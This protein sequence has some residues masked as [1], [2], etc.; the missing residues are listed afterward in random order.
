MTDPRAPK[1]K[2]VSVFLVKPGIAGF[3][4]GKAEKKMGQHGSATNELIFQDCRIGGDALMGRSTT[5]FGW[6]S[7]SWPADASASARSDLVSA[8]R[9]W[10]RPPDIPWSGSS[11]SEN[12]PVSGYS[13]EDRRSLYRT[14]SGAAVAHERRLSE[15]TGQSLCQG[16]LDGQAYL[17]PKPPIGPAMMRC[18]FLAV[19]VTRPIIRLSA[20]PGM[21]E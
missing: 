19:M 3:A 16:G 11:S 17:P 13:M 7:P 6:P 4:I 14:R 18:R 15:G 1:G 10:T 20:T 9:Q 21:Q 8:W 12:Q 2:G 5:V